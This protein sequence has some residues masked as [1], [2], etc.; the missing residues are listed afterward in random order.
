MS[1][2]TLFPKAA[3]GERKRIL[4]K[5]M[6]QAIILSFQELLQARGVG[7]KV[8]LLGNLLDRIDSCCPWFKEEES[9]D[10]REN[11]KSLENHSGR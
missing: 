3:S 5:E 9:L 8:Q 6:H 11:W 2:G 4:K 7:I 1:N 10:I